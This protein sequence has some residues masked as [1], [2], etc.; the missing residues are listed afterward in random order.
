M[1]KTETAFLLEPV[2]G[3]EGQT[4]SHTDGHCDIRTE[5]AKRQAQVKRELMVG[6]ECHTILTILLSNI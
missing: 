5:P 4:D 6:F 2:R 3:G 1:R